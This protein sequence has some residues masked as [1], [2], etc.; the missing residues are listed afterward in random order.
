[1]AFE[2]FATAINC[3]DGR[4]QRP[5]SDWLKIYA[6]ADYVD[7]VTMP[8]PDKVLS[9][10]VSPQSEII[11]EHVDVSVNAHNSA[12]VAVAGH[13]ECAAFPVLRDEHLVAIR[14][15]VTVVASWG[16]A[17]RV[18]GLYVN[19]QWLVEQVADSAAP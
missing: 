11:R 15:A 4:A 6:H 9:S 13:H 7:V 14:Q 5:V 18:V 17:V 12:V 2:T 10:G 1:M 19:A 3:I 16:Y 8:G